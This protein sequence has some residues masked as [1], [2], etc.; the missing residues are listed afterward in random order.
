MIFVIIIRDTVHKNS[1][2][3]TGSRDNPTFAPKGS[4]SNAI[5]AWNYAHIWE[6]LEFFASILKPIIITHRNAL[7]YVL[8]FDKIYL[9][10]DPNENKRLRLRDNKHNDTNYVE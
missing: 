8:N 3:I 7:I 5:H 4:S 1:S 10:S 6:E 9:T 2:D